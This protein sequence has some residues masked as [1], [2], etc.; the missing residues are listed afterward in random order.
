[1]N[2]YFVYKHTNIIN[3]KV[4]IGCSHSLHRM[5]YGSKYSKTS[6]FGKAI[7]KYGWHN[8]KHEIVCSN[9]TQEEAYQMEIELI[10]FYQSNNP[11]YGYNRSV[12]GKKAA[13]GFKHTEEAKKK[14]SQRVSD[15]RKGIKFSEAHKQR[16]KE[17]HADFHGTKSS[18]SK[19]SQ[20]QV[21]EIRKIYKPHDRNFGS[22]ALA[23][24]YGVSATTILDVIHNRTYKDNY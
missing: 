2:D 3:G 24:K 4:Y 23:R 12:G 19:L 16:L 20:I 17:K 5:Q 22:N 10:A 18:L 8:F 21:D 7:K 6:L 15:I 1:M 9:L 14:I 13:L 11:D